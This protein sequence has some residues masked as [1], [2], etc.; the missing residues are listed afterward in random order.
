[1]K[2]KEDEE[3]DDDDDDNNGGVGE[4]IPTMPWGVN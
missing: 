4:L 2:S 3:E 1:V